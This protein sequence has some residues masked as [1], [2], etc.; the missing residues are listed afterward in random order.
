MFRSLKSRVRVV[1]VFLT[2]LFLLSSAQVVSASPAV[3]LVGVSAGPNTFISFVEISGFTGNS[4]RSIAFKI[5]P[6]TGAKAA[7]IQGNYTS[8]YLR[9]HGYLNTLTGIVRVPVYGLYQSYNN[10]VSITYNGTSSR[11]ALNVPIMTGAW[12]DGCNGNYTNQNHLET[13]GNKV[14]LNYSYFMLKGW[15]CGASPIVMDIDGE[16]RWAGTIGSGSQGSSYLGN[17]FYMGYGST[18]YKMELDGTSAEVGNY[19]AQGY[20]DFHH[21]IDPGK[22]GLLIDFNRWP[23]VEANIIEVSKSGALLKEWDI[24]AIID[25]AMIAGGDDPSGFVNHDGG[26]WLHNNAAAYW[27]QKNELVVE[28]TSLSAL[29]MTI[30]RSNGFW[31]IPTKLGINTL[32]F[33][34]THFVCQEEITHRLVITPSQLLRLAT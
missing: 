15:S 34:S 7:Q 20:S 6:K 33:E 8:T 3:A 29:A 17:S 24:G 10:Q 2:S 1:G 12:A 25:Q 22:N 13:P 14:R 30:R 27:R 16:V 19:S 23:D 26:D 31:E 5:Q 28:K 21:N 9:D 32:L 18:L 11:Q 4:L